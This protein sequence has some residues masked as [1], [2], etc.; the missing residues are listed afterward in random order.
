MT[1]AEFIIDLFIDIDS[2]S[3]DKVGT[4]MKEVIKTK[5]LKI[6]TRV[7]IDDVK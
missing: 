5:I 2:I 4:N 7:V 1:N 3:V 6:L